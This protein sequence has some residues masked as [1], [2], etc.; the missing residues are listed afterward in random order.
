MYARWKQTANPRTP[1]EGSAPTEKT[2]VRIA[3]AVYRLE[4]GK[5][6]EYWV[7]IDRLGLEEQLKRQA[8]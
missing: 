1:L 5:I 4:N 3:S 6:A 2:L 8:R 7:Q